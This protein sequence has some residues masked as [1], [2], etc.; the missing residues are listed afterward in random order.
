[1]SCALYKKK[2]HESPYKLFFQPE[3]WSEVGESM[4]L[5]CCNI[6]RVPYRPYLQ[7]W[8]S[9]NLCVRLISFVFQVWRQELMHYQR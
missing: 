1:M 9:S 5:A 2:L 6:E 8:Y 7:T 3:R 4:V